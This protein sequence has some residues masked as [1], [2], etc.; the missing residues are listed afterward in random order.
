MEVRIKQIKSKYNIFNICL[1]FISILVEAT[2]ST[3]VQVLRGIT[4]LSTLILLILIFFH[5]KTRLTFLIFKQRE[6]LDASLYSTGLIYPMIMELII[7]TIHSYPFMDNVRVY[8]DTT[9]TNP[10]AVPVDIDLI[11]SII[12]PWRV[13]LLFRFFAFYSGWT[14]DRAERICNE[15]NANGGVSFAIKA[16]LMERPYTTVGFL[17]ILSILIFGYGL[18]NIELAFM[19]NVPIDKFQDW[20]YIWNGFWCIIITIL[21]VGYGDFYPQTHVGRALT[22]IAC[23]WGTFLISLMVVSMTNSVN[24]TQQEEKAYFEIKKEFAQ[25]NLKNKAGTMIRDA[26]ELKNV[27]EQGEDTSFID[28]KT[29]KITLKEA[30]AKFK[31]SLNEFKSFRKQIISAENEISTETI[32]SK[33]NQ[34][35]SEDMEELINLSKL[36]TTSL[37]GHIGISKELQKQI[38]NYT[39]KLKKLTTGLHKC[40]NKESYKV[41]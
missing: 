20:R 33:L 12:I 18:R 2:P 8:I 32:L 14:D 6:E 24:F 34:C 25:Y 10:I 16:E 30:V 9:G 29:Y 3:T 23:L 21:T 36:H 26:V 17:V 31:K 19:Q 13:Y 38:K 39:E 35:I 15:C 40:V 7:C 22:V 11:I 1:G 5:Y 4:S 41:D 27:I 28:A 37:I